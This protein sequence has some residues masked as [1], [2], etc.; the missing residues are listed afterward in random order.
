MKKGERENEAMGKRGEGVGGR[1][2]SRFFSSF[3]ILCSP[4]LQKYLSS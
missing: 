4:T 1:K 3:Y 2:L